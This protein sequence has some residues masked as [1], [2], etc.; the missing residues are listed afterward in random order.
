LARRQ[1]VNLVLALRA[2]EERAAAGGT[3]I[4][5][6]VAGDDYVLH[7]RTAVQLKTRGQ[8]T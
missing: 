7:L 3:D 2:T 8:C 1:T 4:D 5:Y 6:R